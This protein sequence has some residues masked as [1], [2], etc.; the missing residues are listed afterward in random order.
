MMKDEAGGKIIEE[1]VRLGAKLYSY[2]KF[3]GKEEKKCKGIKKAVINKS[4]KSIIHDD[5]RECSLSGNM[6]RRKMNVIRS[7][8][9]EVF[10]ESINKTA[11]SANDDKKVIRE[12]K[13]PTFSRGHN[14]L[15]Q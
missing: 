10:T 11:L 2:Q 13:T 5:Y 9:H 8:K 3:E 4:I 1:S 7:H 6:Q 12:D 14:Q 15:D